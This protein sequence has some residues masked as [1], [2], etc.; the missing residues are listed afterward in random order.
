[1]C[2]GRLFWIL[3][4]AF[5]A[6]ACLGGQSGN[7]GQPDLPGGSCVGSGQ[8]PVGLD[9]MTTIG[10]AR[11]LLDRFRSPQ[12]ATLTWYTQDG[13]STRIDTTV[14]LSVSGEP[15][16]ASY[17]EF[18]PA[19]CPPTLQVTGGRLRFETADGAF[20][21]SFPGVV[22]ASESGASFDAALPISQF[23]GSYDVARVAQPFDNAQLLLHTSLLPARGTLFMSSGSAQPGSTAGTT[24]IARWTGA[25]HGGT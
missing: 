4:L 14:T 17:L 22:S 11:T 8:R 21:E 16:A 2:S 20:Q 19:G 10:A 3:G 15:E 7:E 18:E 5:G 24:F 12:L 23:A 6:T 1:M 25:G 13:L 9:D